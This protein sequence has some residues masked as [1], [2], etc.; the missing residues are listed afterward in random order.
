MRKLEKYQSLS[1]NLISRGARTSKNISKCRLANR[2]DVLDVDLMDEVGFDNV[3]A[4][5]LVLPTRTV[6]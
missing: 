4:P 2:E 1:D 3:T 6:K 5:G